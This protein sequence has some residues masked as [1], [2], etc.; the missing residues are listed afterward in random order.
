[1]CMYCDGYSEDEVHAHYDE[2]IDRCG[3]MVIHVE[4]N[5]PWAYTIGL[6]ARFDHPEFAVVG[7][8]ARRAHTIINTL[9]QSVAD[10]DWYLP[11][12]TI[13]DGAVLTARTLGVHPLLWE[14]PLFAAWLSYYESRGLAPDQRALQVSL[15]PDEAGFAARRWQPCLDDPDCPVGHPTSGRERHSV[16]QHRRPRR[17][18]PR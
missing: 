7:L 5:P 16:K 12:H 9:A 1:M 2:V 3:W 18:P 17:R 13:G 14:G 11:G 6:S 8:T 10:G 4:G 15:E